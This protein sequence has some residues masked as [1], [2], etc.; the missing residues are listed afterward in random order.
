[1]KYTYPAI[2]EPDEDAIGVSFPDIK[3]CVTFGDDMA[4]AMIMAKDCLEMMLVHYEDEKIP[5]P[6]ASDPRQIKTEHIV[7]CILADTDEWRRQF[8]S[9]SVK[10]TLTV[11]A[12]LNAKAEKAGVNFS[13]VLQDA[14]KKLLNV[15]A[16]PALFAPY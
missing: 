15:D 2:F 5:I 10:K 13:Q 12:W 8:D 4:D 7:T 1:M 6:P 9:R 14:L 16:P 11:P 3:G